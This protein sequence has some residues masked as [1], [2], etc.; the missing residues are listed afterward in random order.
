MYYLLLHAL[1]DEGKDVLFIKALEP[2]ICTAFVRKQKVPEKVPVLSFLIDPECLHLDYFRIR[3][4]FD[5]M[6]AHRVFSRF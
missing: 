3:N 4:T 2:D 6:Y 5:G 1:P